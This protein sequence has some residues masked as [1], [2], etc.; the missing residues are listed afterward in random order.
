[1]KLYSGTLKD[2]I[3][4]EKTTFTSMDALKIAQDIILGIHHI[5][6][7][8]LIHFDIKPAN[9]LVDY[10]VIHGFKCSISDFGVSYFFGNLI[11][12]LTLE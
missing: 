6:R 11:L 3:F 1:M 9:V 7:F 8:G 10:D 2:F 5:H 4:N 12:Y